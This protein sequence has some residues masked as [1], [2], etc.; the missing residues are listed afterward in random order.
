[1]PKHFWTRGEYFAELVSSP[2]HR[3]RVA[4][5]RKL[6]RLYVLVCD[7]YSAVDTLKFFR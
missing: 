6:L 4:M 3:Q 2:R 7:H 5:D 1:M